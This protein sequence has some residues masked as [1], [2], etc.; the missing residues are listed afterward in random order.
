[1]TLTTLIKECTN[2][3]CAVTTVLRDDEDKVVAEKTEEFSNREVALDVV[4]GL[5]DWA[6]ARGIG[7][8]ITDV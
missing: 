2:G 8:G 7:I 1:M 4:Q 3:G 6:R 5:R